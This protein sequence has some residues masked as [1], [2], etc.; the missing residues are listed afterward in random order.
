MRTLTTT[1]LG[2]L[3]AFFSAQS[4]FAKEWRGIVPLRSV[5]ADVERLLGPPSQA[6][7]YWSYYIL[8]GELAVVH[9]QSMSCKDSC[10]VGW[11]VPID[12]VIGIG[13]IPKGV[14]CR[15]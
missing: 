11:D 5:R 1:T 10:R 14:M 9:F 12:T 15:C 6:S 4:V 7:P 13:V 8:P 2:V 3:I